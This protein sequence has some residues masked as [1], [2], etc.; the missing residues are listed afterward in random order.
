LKASPLPGFTSCRSD[1]IQS[2]FPRQRIHC[3]F[4]TRLHAV[5]PG[6]CSGTRWR[7][8]VT[9]SDVADVIG[10]HEATYQLLADDIQLYSGR[11]DRVASSIQRRRLM[12]CTSG[13]AAWW[14]H[15]PFTTRRRQISSH[16]HGS[17]CTR[18]NV[19]MQLNSSHK[20]LMLGA[21]NTDA[22]QAA[23]NLSVRSGSEPYIYIYSY[24][25]ALN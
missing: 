25:Y 17:A 13:F 19:D 3:T 10:T 12:G 22:V 1:R 7:S 16:R 18:A 14:H 2:F 21:V 8:S 4:P 6:F 20:S 5:C 11:L 23:R 15:S 9:Q 24:I